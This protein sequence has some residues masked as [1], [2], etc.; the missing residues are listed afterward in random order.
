MSKRRKPLV[1]LGCYL[2][3]DQ[4]AGGSN[5]SRRTKW[6]R[7]ANVRISVDFAE[8]YKLCGSIILF[9]R[10]PGKCLAIKNSQN[11]SNKNNV[12]MSNWMSKLMSKKRPPSDVESGLFYSARIFRM[13]P[14]YTLGLATCRVSI[15]SSM[16]A[17]AA[18]GSLP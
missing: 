13:T 11:Q 10:K 4:K 2:P 18:D 14:L 17:H 12:L 5:P 15:R 6:N 3:T 16:T 9:L 8:L 1:S 7:A